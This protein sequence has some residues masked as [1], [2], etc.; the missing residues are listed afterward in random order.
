MIPWRQDTVRYTLIDSSG[1]F[2]PEFETNGK[3]GQSGSFP[4]NVDNMFE[5]HRVQ[6]PAFIDFG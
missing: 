4:A 6:I 1:P 5:V 2:R 3:E